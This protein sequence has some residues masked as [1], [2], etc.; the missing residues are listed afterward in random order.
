MLDAAATL[1][2]TLIQYMRK[3]KEAY[4]IAK[5]RP[6]FHWLFDIVQQL[7]EDDMVHDCFIIERLHLRIKLPGEKVDTM[8]R[9]ERSVLAEALNHQ[10]QDLRLLKGPCHVIDNAVA[11]LDEFPNAIF[12]KKIR[13]MGMSLA[14]ADVVFWQEC[15]GEILA[16]GQEGDYFFVVLE[17]WE[18]LEVWT[19]HATTWTATSRRRQVCNEIGNIISI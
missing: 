19:S 7:R 8:R 1:E 10:V 15:A 4:G 6:K 18:M 13:V 3:H 14:A 11:H 9:Y 12:C 5:I 16:C 2:V 17:L